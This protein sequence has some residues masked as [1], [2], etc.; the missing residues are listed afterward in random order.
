M[1]SASLV[2][3]SSWL[4]FKTLFCN[5]NSQSEFRCVLE[6]TVISTSPEDFSLVQLLTCAWKCRVTKGCEW[7]NTHLVYPGGSPCLQR[8][9]SQPHRNVTDDDLW[10][11]VTSFAL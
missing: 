5:L 1:S 4:G 9:K 7:I 6:S 2:F 3:R 8:L 10:R 11:E